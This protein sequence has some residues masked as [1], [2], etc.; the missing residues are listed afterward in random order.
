MPNL[1]HPLFVYGVAPPQLQRTYIALARVASS[2]YLLGK[3]WNEAK[4]ELL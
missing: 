3:P 4:Q 1:S 2:R